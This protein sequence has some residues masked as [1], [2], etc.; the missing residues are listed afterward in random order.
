M[1]VRY[2]WNTVEQVSESQFEVKWTAE[3][4]DTSIGFLTV[5]PSKNSDYAT[6]YYPVEESLFKILKNTSTG[7]NLIFNRLVCTEE[8]EVR[9]VRLKAKGY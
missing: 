3:A 1:A 2:S 8:L 9:N 4:K 6:E 5:R 7:Y